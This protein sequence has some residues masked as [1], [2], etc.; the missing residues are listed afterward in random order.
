MTQNDLDDISNH[1][2]EIYGR[3]SRRV[4][5][6]LIRLIRDFDLAEE[7]MHEAFAAAVQQWPDEGI[8]ANPYS[9]L[10]SAA[11]F[12]AIDAIRRRSRFAKVQPDLVVRLEEVHEDN[13]TLANSEIKDDRLRLIFTCCHPAIDATVQ[14]PLTLRE[15]CGLRACKTISYRIDLDSVR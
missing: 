12:K 15:V 5:A 4:L 11:R 10:V 13:E 14:V 6:T 8:P 7:M 9:W 2:S 3:E 1:I